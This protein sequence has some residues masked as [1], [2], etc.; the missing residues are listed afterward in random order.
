MN[1]SM[2]NT[3]S[4]FSLF[5]QLIMFSGNIFSCAPKL[6]SIEVGDS[7]IPR[8]GANHYGPTMTP[9]ETPSNFLQQPGPIVLGD[10]NVGHMNIQDYENLWI[11]RSS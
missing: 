9:F 11:I 3:T 4:D 5:A 2:D 7:G 6:M 1:S 8:E 10:K